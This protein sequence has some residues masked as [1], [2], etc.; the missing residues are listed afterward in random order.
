MGQDGALGSFVVDLV[1]VE[2]GE[3]IEAVKVL[4]IC[5]NFDAAAGLFDIDQGLE[6]LALAILDVLAHRVQVGRI[7]DT[8]RENALAVF[9]FTLAEQLL[10]P[11]REEMQAGFVV[12]HDLDVVALA[13]QDIA[14][15]RILVAG[16]LRQF[17]IAELLHGVLGSAHELTDVDSGDSDRQQANGS[18]DRVAAADVIRHNKGLVTF[19]ISQTF[20]RATGLVGRGID[21]G[22]GAF[23][24]VFFFHVGFENP[25][26]DRRLGGGTRLGNDIDRNV[27]ALEQVEQVGQIGRADRIAGKNDLRSFAQAF[28]E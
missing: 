11:F 28:G 13:E 3:E 26:S 25:E 4:R 23:L 21:A 16:V 17:R 22:T 10:P 19:A 27:L 18:Q 14:G 6:Q 15:S 2:A 12:D 8:G 24:A 7:V 20:E 5:G 1:H 9:T